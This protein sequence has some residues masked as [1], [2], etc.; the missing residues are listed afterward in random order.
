MNSRTKIWLA[1][2]A[3]LLA[4]RPDHAWA[5]GGV[6]PGGT[7]VQ[8]AALP[9]PNKSPALCGSADT[10]ETGIQGDVPGAGGA[11]CGLTFLTQLSSSLGGSIQGA[12]HCAYVR[13]ATGMYGSNGVMKAF[14]LADPLH[15]V[16][17]DEAPLYGG[18]EGFRTQ[19][20]NGRAIL[21]SGRGVY[22]ISDCEHLVFKGEI[23]WPSTNS[24]NGA[25]VAGTSSHE[26][27]IS[28]DARRVYSGLGFA[29]A[30]L[31]NLEDPSTWQVYNHTCAIGR[32][33]GWP[34]YMGPEGSPTPCDI[35]PQGDW[36]PEYSHSSDDNLEGTR[37][38][39]ANQAATGTPGLDESPTH[40]RIV[41]IS[42]RGNPRILDTITE[43]PGHALDWWR[44]ADGREYIVGSNELG[45]GDTCQPHPR[46]TSLLNAADA[47]VAEVTGDHFIKASTVS[48]MINEPQNC[49]AKSASGS[50]A[51]LSEHTI[52]DKHG[53]AVLMLEFGGAGFRVFDVRDGYHPKEVAYFNR[54]GG[55]HSGRFYY[56]DARGIL[57]T[58]ASSGMQVLEVQPQVITALGLPTPTD[59]AYPRYPNG[60]PATP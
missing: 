40:A 44:S 7:T 45:T 9:D 6:V 39:G 50:N 1:G 53:A 2:V 16:Q 3:V 31:D 49:A 51:F 58:P 36:P 29:A 59:P 42:Q 57:L 24:R 10:P 18:S 25:T 48:L 15:P 27:A 30:Y 38:Y 21:V 47:Y 60:R 37:W 4:T 35:A 43:F 23:Q 54:G 33:A 34:L 41:D 8:A 56:D 55:V 19:V 12:G 28:H 22:D 17:T 20:A 46:S 11:N 26:L 32:Q 14:S 5:I 52:Y 13:N